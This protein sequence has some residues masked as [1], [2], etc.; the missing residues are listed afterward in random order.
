MLRYPQRL[1]VILLVAVAAAVPASAAT[2]PALAQPFDVLGLANGHLLV[3]DLQLGRVLDIDPAHRSGRIAGA[4]REARE[5]QRLPDGRLLVSSRARVYALDPR[6]RKATLYATFRNY[7]LG[8]AVG[9]DGWLYGSEN[10]PGSETTTIVRVKAG[11]REVLV[12]TLHGVHEMLVERDGTLILCEAYGGRLLRLD[13]AT[14]AVTVLGTRMKN[15][16]SAVDAA[17]GGWLVSE[18]FGNRVSHVWPDGHI[19]KVADVFKPGAIAYD[20]K[21]RLVGTDGN[22]EIWRLSHGAAQT[23]YP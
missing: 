9:R 7:L 21:H 17:G 12:P 11:T 2:E 3:S 1:L 8:I 18:F 4:V 14:R 10:V 13:P 22:G 15:P 23:I 5:L 19:T 6:T 16:S 20:S